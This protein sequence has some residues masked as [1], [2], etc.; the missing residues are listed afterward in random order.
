MTEKKLE[1]YDDTGYAE[2]KLKLCDFRHQE[3]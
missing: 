1:G 3:K 2:L